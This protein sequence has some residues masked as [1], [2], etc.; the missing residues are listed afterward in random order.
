M[1]LIVGVGVHNPGPHVEDAGVHSG[2]LLAVLAVL[3]IA[4]C[5]QQVPL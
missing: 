4:D 5:P 1:I 2:G 3:P